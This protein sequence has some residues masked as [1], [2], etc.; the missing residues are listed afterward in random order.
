MF[1]CKMFSAVIEI[2]QLALPLIGYG[3]TVVLSSIV[4]GLILAN[5][6]NENL[7]AGAIIAITQ[8][9]LMM[10]C[11]SALF[12]VSPVVGRLDAA[13]NHYAIGGIIQQGFV[14][15][16]LISLPAIIFLSCLKKILLILGQDIKI[17]EIV[18]A[19]FEGFAWGI[20]SAFMIT[21]LQQFFTG[22]KKTRVIILIGVTG[23]FLTIILGYG[24][25]FGKFGL[26]NLGVK[27]LGISQSLR[28]WIIFTAIFA[29][30][31]FKNEF[32]KFSLFT[33]KHTNKFQNLKH[34]FSLGWPI[35]I[36]AASEFLS[37]FALTVIAGTLSPQPLPLATQQVSSQYILLLS[38][39]MIA[40]GQASSIIVAKYIAQ[41]D[42]KNTNRFANAGMMLGIIIGLTV[43]LAFLICSDV[44]ISPYVD[45]HNSEN[46]ALVTMIKTFLL[47]IFIGQVIE[48]VGTIVTFLLRAMYETKIPMIINLF[49]RWGV[50]IP[51][52]YFLSQPQLFGINGIAISQI[53]GL[54]ICVA[55]IFHRWRSKLFVISKQ[56]KK[57]EKF[58]HEL[59]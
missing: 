35:S 20:P 47:L 3:I 31:F 5:L 40:I 43:I 19:Y 18:V 45:I 37:V 53:I 48:F 14:F 6:G 33:S 23:L 17:V 34:I 36:H 26:P 59:Y 50:I 1:K 27:G 15:A 13:Q 11:T 2:A 46:I 56:N 21:N 8:S 12:S 39:P 54:L 29:T 42:L 58:A 4:C 52:A 22:I 57:I 38:I 30:L 10:I 44:F 28:S 7:A 49:T 9:C 24:L 55:L 51:S 25:T 16:L 32:N 41:N